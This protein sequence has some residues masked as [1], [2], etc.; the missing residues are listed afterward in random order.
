M[1]FAAAKACVTPDEPVF[2]AGFGTRDRKC[3]GV[4]DD[5][6]VKVAVLEE[7]DRLVIITIDAL[8]GDRSFVSGIRQALEE[9][10]GF[11]PEQV[12][13]NFSHTHCSV[14]LTGESPEGRRGGY[15]L[16]QE[17]WPERDED[18]DYREDIRYFG[19]LRSVIVELTGQCLASLTEG[20]VIVSKGISY[21]GISRRLITQDGVQMKPNPEAEIDKDLF[22]LQLLDQVGTCRAVLFS[23]ACHPTCIGGNHIS[24]EFVGEACREL[25]ASLPGAAALFLQGCAADVRPSLSVNGD[26]FKT[27]TVQEMR[28]AGKALAADVVQTITATRPAQL[29]GPLAARELQIRLFTEPWGLEQ[30]QAIADDETKTAYKRRA[31]KR[32]IQAAQEGRVRQALP[33]TVQCWELGDRLTLVALEGEVPAEYALT[34]K[35]MLAGANNDTIVLA[36]S[37]GV[38][39]YIPSRRIL[40]EGGYEAEAFILHGY[41]GPFVPENEWII[42]GAVKALTHS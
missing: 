36:Y 34:I 27:C 31:A 42:L 19:R 13:L 24:A 29:I 26:R 20:T 5:L 37:N 18:T 12:L 2:L 10:F 9:R 1:K 3:D 21:A 14:F 38:P 7:G 15:S 35:R 6:F 30:L 16:G 17:R 8:G 11:R 22:V 41:R 40:K 32:A 33:Y 28:N 23:Y 39:T 4:L 25:E